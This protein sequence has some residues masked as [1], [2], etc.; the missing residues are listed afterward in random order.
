MQTID[1]KGNA[2]T[3]TGKK[4]AKLIRKNGNVPC[5]L[6]G[7]KNV[8]FS[9]SQLELRKLTNTA[10][11]YLVNLD[12]DGKK[13]EAVLRETQ[14][15]PVT[16]KLIHAD[17]E[18]VKAGKNVKVSLPVRTNG[19]APGVIAGGKL[20]ANMR[21]VSVKGELNKIPND[22][23]V[24]ISPL[25]IGDKIRISDINLEGVTLTDPASNVIVAVATTRVS[26]KAEGEEETTEEG[27]ATDGATPAA[28]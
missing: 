25:N 21:K 10:E 9:A 4:A 26:A 12:V 24:D 23:T 19:I 8:H 20:K 18:S 6:Y 17:F 14:Y 16:D 15:H 3:E 1:V 22:I 7:E 2:R 27:E 11:T 13:Y 5:E 28:E